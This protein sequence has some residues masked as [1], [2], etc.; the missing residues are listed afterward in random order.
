M[1]ADLVD[2]NSGVLCCVL[3]SNTIQV[4]VD[5]TLCLKNGGSAC[6]LNYEEQRTRTIRVRATDNGS[7]PLSV[8]LTVTITLRDINDQPRNL[9]LSKIT[10]SL[11]TQ[12]HFATDLMSAD[13]TK[14]LILHYEGAQEF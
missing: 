4:A 6:K 2:I 11:F 8:T 3:F 7:P 5:N 14:W 10:V 1:L 12:P 13:V 9:D